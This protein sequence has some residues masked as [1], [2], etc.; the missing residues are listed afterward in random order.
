MI[1][2]ND[3]IKYGKTGEIIFKEDFLDFLG[4]KYIDVSGCQ[5]FQKIDSD[6][7]TW[8]ELI[9]VKLNYKDNGFIVFEHYTNY[10][11][12]NHPQNSWGW[13][14]ES[15][16]NIMVFISKKTRYMIFLPFNDV[17]K[18]HYNT[19]QKKYDLKQ[20]DYSTNNKSIWRSAFKMIPLTDLTGYY[21]VYQRNANL[22]IIEQAIEVKKVYAETAKQLTLF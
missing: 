1:N 19:I 16:A 11:S 2:F 9:E 14:I 5:Q 3:S 8:L 17:F 10:I 4:V 6:F 7:K 15:K 20:N 13:L 12:P 21:S 18:K 22:P